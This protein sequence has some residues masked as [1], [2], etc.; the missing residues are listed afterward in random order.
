MIIANLLFLAI[1]LFCLPQPPI[2]PLDPG[3]S[4]IT[5]EYS[6]I[7]RGVDFGTQFKPQIVYA[8]QDGIVTMTG[9]ERYGRGLHVRI[10]HTRGTVSVYAH[11]S[12]LLVSR[13]DCVLSGQPIALSGGHPENQPYSGNSTGYH[14]HF[15][16]WIHGT[17]ANPF[18]CFP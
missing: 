5:A 2:C 13:G 17:P 3:N 1:L 11:L 18:F 10:S 16:Y 8:I 6:T 7:H 12:R 9:I 4:Y 15:E 14:L